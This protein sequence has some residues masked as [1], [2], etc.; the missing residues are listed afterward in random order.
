MYGP[1]AQT[2]EQAAAFGLNKYF[3]GAECKRGHISPKYV[4]KAKC[5]ECTRQASQLRNGKEHTRYTCYR[6]YEPLSERIFDNVMTVPESGCWI[7]MRALNR[8]GYG[9]LTYL[10]KHME[11]HRASWIAHRGEIPNGVGVLH[12][13]NIRSCVNPDHLYLGGQKENVADAISAGTFR[14]PP[15]LPGSLHPLAKLIEKQARRIKYGGESASK[16]AGALG[17]KVQ[18]VYAIRSGRQWKH[19]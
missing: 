14:C 4:L 11:A 9:Q 7:W 3:D 15:A 6:G 1:F 12:R 5:V 2:P 19:I 8:S 10:K 18:S 13:C 16:V 17:V